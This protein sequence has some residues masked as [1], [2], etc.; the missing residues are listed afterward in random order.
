M[1]E[2]VL[3][4]PTSF[5]MDYCDNCACNCCLFLLVRSNKKE[6][7][8]CSVNLDCSDIP[9]TLT[10]NVDTESHRSSN[11]VVY[12]R[13]SRLDFTLFYL[14]QKNAMFGTFS[15]TNYSQGVEFTTHCYTFLLKSKVVRKTV[16]SR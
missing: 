1:L 9:V 11:E 3:K 7:P 10:L 12:E 6:S 8:E 2:Q 5:S 13:L 4:R 15:C 14:R 16:Y